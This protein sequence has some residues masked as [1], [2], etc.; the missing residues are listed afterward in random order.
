MGEPCIPSG[1]HDRGAPQPRAQV[2]SSPEPRFPWQGWCRRRRWAEART[3]S[4]E[5]RSLVGTLL[6]WYLPTS[7]LF[8]NYLF[9]VNSTK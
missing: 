8:L 2:P 5:R 1:G 4:R 3:R 6:I 7:V 9:Y